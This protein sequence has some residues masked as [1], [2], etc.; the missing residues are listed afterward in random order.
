MLKFVAGYLTACMMF[1]YNYKIIKFL[2]NEIAKLELKQGML[3]H[4]NPDI[5]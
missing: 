4:D 1:K 2:E 5:S 3:R